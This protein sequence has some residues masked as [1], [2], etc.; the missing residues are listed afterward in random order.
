MMS[1]SIRRKIYTLLKQSPRLINI[2]FALYCS[3]DVYKKYPSEEGLN[4]IKLVEDWLN[5]KEISDAMYQNYMLSVCKFSSTQHNRLLNNVY[6]FLLYSLDANSSNI[7]ISVNASAA[8]NANN[9]ACYAA[10]IFRFK[11]EKK[12]QEYYNY[13]MEEVNK[14]SELEKIIYGIKYEQY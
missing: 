14:L 2:R 5:G 8:D 12:L 10:Q 11:L 3:K 6:Y 13:L 9:T 4:C 1:E 7:F